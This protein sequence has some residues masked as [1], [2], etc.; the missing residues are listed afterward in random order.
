MAQFA[1]PGTATTEDVVPP[2]TFSSSAGFNL[3]GT[4]AVKAQSGTVTSSSATG[5]FTEYGGTSLTSAYTATI[6]VPSGATQI[7]G[8]LTAQYDA[9]TPPAAQGD[10]FSMTNAM[11]AGYADGATASILAVMAV[12]TANNYTDNYSV[13]AGGDLSI[14]TSSIV[15]PVRE[16]SYTTYY[17]VYY[18]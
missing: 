5:T 15:L 12:G 2:K 14:S 4:L 17:T 7:I 18:I 11:A 8:V 13:I 10:A 9:T 16:A 6:P 1:I 3:T